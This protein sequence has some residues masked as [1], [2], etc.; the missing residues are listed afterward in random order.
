MV[1][2][3]ILMRHAEREDRAQ[4]LKGIDWIS[5]APRPQDPVLSE[6][7]L[8]CFGLCVLTCLE[9]KSSFLLFG[10]LGIQQAKNAG[11]QMKNWGITKILSSPMIRTVQTSDIVAEQIGLGE[12]S[13]C[14][15]M[16]LVEEAKSFRGKT[17][18]EPRPNWNPLIL[19]PSELA[20][21]SRR[22]NLDYKTILDVQHVRD[23]SALNTVREVH[24]TLKDRDEVTRNR[25][26]TALSR[27]LAE[28]SLA[29]DV[30]LCVGHGATVKSFALVLEAGLPEEHKCQGER[31]VSCFA[32]F[33]PVDPANPSGP[34]RSVLPEW[35]TG[36]ITRTAAEAPEDQG[37]GSSGKIH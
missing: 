35:S 19:P 16:G 8:D 14:V 15:E 20:A 6:G 2:S 30:V 3:I 32:E 25:C 4:E 17:A 36:D 31:T 34:W 10:T 23:E 9:I 33:R 37:F 7:G 22:L 24:D 12:N 13:I 5:T 1:K 29:D 18:D 26:R 21:Y 11:E 28:E 27:F